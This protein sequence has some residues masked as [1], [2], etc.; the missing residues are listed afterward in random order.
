MAEITPPVSFFFLDAATEVSYN[1]YTTSCRGTAMTVGQL[2]ELIA[3]DLRQVK[4]SMHHLRVESG[5]WGQV[6]E[7]ER[8]VIA[9]TSAEELERLL[10]VVALFKEQV[11]KQAKWS[12]RK[13]NETN[14]DAIHPVASDSVVCTSS[15]NLENLLIDSVSRR[16]TDEQADSYSRSRVKRGD[17]RQK[18][19]VT[20][21]K[22]HSV[23]ARKAK[24]KGIAG[25]II[26]ARSD[27]DVLDAILTP[28]FAAYNPYSP[29]VLG[30]YDEIAKPWLG[31]DKAERPQ[32]DRAWDRIEEAHIEVMRAAVSGSPGRRVL[33]TVPTLFFLTMLACRGGQAHELERLK[34][35]RRQLARSYAE[36]PFVR[37]FLSALSAYCGE[38]D[39]F[40]QFVASEEGCLNEGGGAA[41]FAGPGIGPQF[42][43]SL[44]TAGITPEFLRMHSIGG[45]KIVVGVARHSKRIIDLAREL[46]SEV[47]EALTPMVL[48]WGLTVMD[49]LG[50]R[51]PSRRIGEQLSSLAFMLV[52]YESRLRT[53]GLPAQLFD[54]L[55]QRL[56]AAGVTPSGRRNFRQ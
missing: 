37:R 15:S 21:Y 24:A 32:W 38:A 45:E 26:D 7:V 44:I 13:K 31:R 46:R 53:G 52:T 54:K 1:P 5:E 20:S 9:A 12:R 51:V 17:R 18:G 40:W 3:K 4:A 10:S 55:I 39:E 25:L 42:A 49:V 16:A 28:E 27:S 2:Q 56:Q 35:L 11:N 47:R 19:R 34:N 29:D 48:A 43:S 22:T 14:F 30:A 33:V 23:A 8:Q 36:R 50:D 6:K 41:L